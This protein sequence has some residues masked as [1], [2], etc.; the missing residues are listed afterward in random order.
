[1]ITVTAK[2]PIGGLQELEIVFAPQVQHYVWPFY[3]RVA[4]LICYIVGLSNHD[5]SILSIIN[6]FRHQCTD[7]HETDT[8]SQVMSK[9]VSRV[10]SHLCLPFK[11]PNRSQDDS[12][13]R[14]VPYGRGVMGNMVRKDLTDSYYTVLLKQSQVTVHDCSRIG[15]SSLLSPTPQR[16]MRSGK[17]TIMER[18]IV[19]QEDS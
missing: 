13:I 8:I 4:V 19:F 17:Q 1:M 16:C 7:K 10:L 6:S 15:S 14:L 3:S 9:L 2:D 11:I 5:L 18:V 12:K